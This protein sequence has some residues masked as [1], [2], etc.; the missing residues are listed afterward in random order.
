[1][2]RP[3][4]RSSRTFARSSRL[5]PLAVRRKCV[6]GMS[7]EARCWRG[8]AST[9]CSIRVRHSLSFRR[10]LRMGSTAAGVAFDLFRDGGTCDGPQPVPA[11]AWFEHDTDAE[12]DIIEDAVPVPATAAVLSLIWIPDKAARAL[13]LDRE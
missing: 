2:P 12:V 4:G 7:R 8:N 11:D 9:C 10:S 5:L 1:M 13:R 3:W 6:P